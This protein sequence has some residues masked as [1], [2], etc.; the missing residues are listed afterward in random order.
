M[1]IATNNGVPIIQNGNFVTSCACCGWTCYAPDAGACCNGTQCRVV[2]QCDCNAAAGE[3]FKGVGT[4]CSPNPCCDCDS[5]VS[6]TVKLSS[7]LLSQAG[8]EITRTGCGVFI[9]ANRTNVVLLCDPQGFRI[10]VTNYY[11]TIADGFCNVSY[12]SGFVGRQYISG[13]VPV[14]TSGPCGT[15]TLTLSG[16][17]ASGWPTA[18]TI[19]KEDF[20]TEPDS[21]SLY[22]QI[23]TQCWGYYGD[24]RND[25]I[26]PQW[27]KIGPAASPLP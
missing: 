5:L 21:F 23:P 22:D 10:R 15:V 11:S 13:Y 14:S 6:V 24:P 25:L 26:F 2:Q 1:T 9:Q 18:T 3:V 12:P 20:T 7:S 4:T 17:G 16:C 19:A 8:E 27:V